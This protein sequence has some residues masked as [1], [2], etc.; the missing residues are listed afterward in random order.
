MGSYH[1]AQIANLVLALREFKFWTFYRHSDILLFVRYIDDGLIIS[2]RHASNNI[3]IIQTL[4]KLYPKSIP[5]N[6][7]I[8]SK[9]VNFLDLT[10]S[11]NHHTLNHNQIHYC[12]YQKLFQKFTYV[13]FKSNH[14]PSIFRSI[15][16]GECH[17]YR[18]HSSNEQDY[19]HILQLF[20]I[21]LQRCG[22]PMRYIKNNSL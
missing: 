11:V 2:R 14:Y 12:I 6:F 19:K 8:N 13:S 4:C 16:Q 5:I 17:R 18:S 9:T 22:Y 3:D 1:S 10:L 15:I 20:R 7:V 21:R